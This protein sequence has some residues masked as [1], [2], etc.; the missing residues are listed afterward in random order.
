MLTHAGR[1]VYPILL[2][3]EEGVISTF[4]VRKLWSREV[5]DSPEV[6][7]AGRQLQF[8]GGKAA[9]LAV[10]TLPLPM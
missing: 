1:F 9:S 10:L 3:G 6:I 4:P 7:K 2:R 5:L 8:E